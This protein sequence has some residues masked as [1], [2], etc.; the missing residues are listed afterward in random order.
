MAILA[1]VALDLKLETIKN[2]I[3]LAILF[4]LS[5]K[6]MQVEASLCKEHINISSSSMNAVDAA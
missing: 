2:L 1:L 4:M 5:L 3:R 6:S